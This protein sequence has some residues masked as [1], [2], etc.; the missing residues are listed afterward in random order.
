MGKL[1]RSTLDGYAG[2]LSRYLLDDFGPLAIASITPAHCERL[3]TALVRQQS[4]QSAHGLLDNALT[5]G[6]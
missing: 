6:T 2:V 4:R 5:P 3:L 1:K